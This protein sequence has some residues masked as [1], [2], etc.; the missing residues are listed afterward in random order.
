MN[1][2]DI[3]SNLNSAASLIYCILLLFVKGGRE[4]PDD[5]RQRVTPDGT[6]EVQ[7]VQK[8]D[9]AGVYTC[10]ARNK[11]GHVARRSGEVAVIGKE[12]HP[13]ISDVITSINYYVTMVLTLLYG[14]IF[15]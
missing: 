6:L 3:G 7:P 5:L 4:L 1:V 11:Q 12:R 9:D 8:A 15:K 14:H 13:L 10:W 2:C